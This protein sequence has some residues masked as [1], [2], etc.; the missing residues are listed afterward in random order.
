METKSLDL[1]KLYDQLKPFK[2]TGVEGVL[3]GL[4]IGFV[5]GKLGNFDL[6]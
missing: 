6:A 2:N 3:D 1:N 5:Q 4:F